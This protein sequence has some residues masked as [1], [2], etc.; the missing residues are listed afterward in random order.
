MNGLRQAFRSSVNAA[1]LVRA[2]L[3]AALVVAIVAL[4][5]ATPRAA[6]APTQ[7][8]KEINAAVIDCM[9][10][11]DELGYQG[12]YNRLQPVLVENFDFPLMARVAVGRH[13]RDLGN[14]QR[15]RLIDRFT[16]MSIATFAARFDGYSGQRF[17][18]DGQR[19][20][21]R[22]SVLVDNALVMSDGDSVNIN[23]LLRESDSG[24]QVVDVYLDAKYSELAM[25]RSEYSSVIRRRGFD[26]LIDS[27]DREIGKLESPGPGAE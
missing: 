25:K 18:V 26:G 17:R 13:W 4:P 1:A 19:P 7:I 5:A 15:Q 8:V 3:T 16:K 11:A 22:G 2:V 6:P 20:G 14:A 9:K 10:R 21:L 23:Y 12:R 27:I 24:W